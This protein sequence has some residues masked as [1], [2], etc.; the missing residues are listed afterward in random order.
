MLD[1][2]T[3]D[4]AA[5]ESEQLARRFFG[6]IQ[7]GERDV[8]LDLVHPDIEWMLKS[9]HSGDVLRGRGDVEAFFA[10]IAGRFY[11]L[12]TEVYR[13][14]DDERIVVEGR[15]RWTDDARILR[16]DPVIWALV[17]RDGLLW[18]STPAPSLAEAEA[19]LP[20]GR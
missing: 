14:L 17:F 13:P 9:T 11:E 4:V 3:L 19:L 8:M 20:T 12:V 1:A 5:P 15:L 18:R 16:D 10:E 2:P 6:R 7:R